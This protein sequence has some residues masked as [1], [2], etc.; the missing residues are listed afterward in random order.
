[1]VDVIIDWSPVSNRAY[2]ILRAS[3]AFEQRSITLY[4][5][6]HPEANLGNF[7]IHKAF[8]N[9]LKQIIPLHTKPIIITDSGFRTEWF[10]LV[11]SLGWEFEGRVC[12]NMQYLL[13]NHDSW[14]KTEDL[15]LVSI[16][17]AIYIGKVLLTKARQLPCEMYAYLGKRKNR[18]TSHS[19]RRKG[20]KRNSPRA[21]RRYRNQHTQ[22]WILITSMQHKN[23][24]DAKAIV[25]SYSRRMK[26]EHEFRTT[27]NTKWGLGLTQTLTRDKLR[28]EILLLIGTIAMLYLWLVGLVAEYRNLQYHYQVNTIKT[29]RVLSLIFLGLQVIE[30]QS[31]LITSTELKT[32][33]F[34]AQKDE[35]NAYF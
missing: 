1:M 13:D 18:T 15:K 22:S 33:L 30:H 7:T 14:K 32:A 9:N 8:L 20:R 34:Y 16:N 24:L 10:E 6:V 25:K 4:E 12:N 5:E 28:L 2:Y 26:I 21:N 23:K 27:K 19:V 31:N 11:L 35:E 29:R 3:L 17:K